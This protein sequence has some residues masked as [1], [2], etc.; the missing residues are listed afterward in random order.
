[1]IFAFSY[2][3][4]VSS[5]VIRP[6]VISLYVNGNY[7]FRI[8]YLRR[9]FFKVV[10]SMLLNLILP[11]INVIYFTKKWMTILTRFFFLSLIRFLGCQCFNTSTQL[12]LWWSHF[13]SG[14]GNFKIKCGRYSEILYRF[15]S[16][17]NMTCLYLPRSSA[18]E[19]Q[20]CLPEKSKGQVNNLMISY[21]FS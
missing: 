17:E 19:G 16:K 15:F 12:N 11:S 9:E 6:D 18:F 13:L 8:I 2:I 7:N 5:I 20:F 14:R 21:S 4:E 10:F 3:C 1:M